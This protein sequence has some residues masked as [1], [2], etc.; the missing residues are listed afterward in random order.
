MLSKHD[1]ERKLSNVIE[2]NGGLKEQLTVCKTTFN[3]Q[4]FV[5][6]K[7]KLKILIKLRQIY[8]LKCKMKDIFF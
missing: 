5:Q 7:S 1:V 6:R 3:I 8:G 2:E 4:Y